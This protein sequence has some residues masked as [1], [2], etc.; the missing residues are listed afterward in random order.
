MPALD[1]AFFAAVNLPMLDFTSLTGPRAGFE[2]GM[3]QMH[4]HVS[5]P[6]L[7]C[8]RDM[9]AHCS[10]ARKASFGACMHPRLCGMQVSYPH[11]WVYALS[12]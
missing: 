4:C 9:S 7:F 1:T 2:T 3:A 12:T 10:W 5:K 11:K 8:P 6:M